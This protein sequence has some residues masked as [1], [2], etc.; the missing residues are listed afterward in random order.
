MPRFFEEMSIV[1]FGSCGAFGTSILTGARIT[2]GSVAA[3]AVVGVIC[4]VISS[5]MG[6]EKSDA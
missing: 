1:A 5:F 2:W 6:K 4:S 3:L